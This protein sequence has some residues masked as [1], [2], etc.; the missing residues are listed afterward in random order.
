[1]TRA[2]PVPYVAATAAAIPAY[3]GSMPARLRTLAQHLLGSLW[4]IPSA[5]VFA[6][7]ALAVFM[8]ELSG[9]MGDAVLERFPRLFGASA[10]S[11]Q[12]MLSAI[13]GS[14][15]TVAGLSFSLV[16]LAV[17]QASSQYTPRILRTFM[18]DRANQ[19]VLGTFV[20]IFAYCLVVLR[21]IRTAD[22]GGFVPSLAVVL[23]IVLAIAGIG[24]LIYFVHHIASTL[25]A[26]S[27]MARVTRDTVVVVDRLFPQTLGDE[28]PVNG[29]VVAA[30][31]ALTDWHL[32]RAAATGYVQSVDEKGMLRLAAQTC[33]VIRMARGIGDFV[34]EGTE[35]AAFADWPP[36]AQPGRSPHRRDTGP[37]PAE[38]AKRLERLYVV[39]EYRTVAQDAAFGIRQLVD[40][41]L[42]ALSRGVND[43][44]TAVNCVD[45]IGAI[46]VRLANRQVE[47]PLRT[48]DGIVR[49]IARG[50]QF[51]GLLRLACDE[52]RN[53]AAGNP[54]MLDHLFETLG[55]VAGQTPSQDRRQLLAEQVRLIREVVSRTVET[56]HDRTRLESTADRV[57]AACER[58]P[59]SATRRGSARSR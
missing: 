37:D 52:I 18:E 53:S 57:A 24:V 11:S 2:A 3:S 21:T 51:D 23:A 38:I 26:S 30:I 16:L 19:V 39:D 20:G 46:L 9:G 42:R 7:L 15:I 28:G 6:A 33:Q 41:A 40:I 34:I 22:E 8:V 29:E 31:E 1:M 59:D 56:P 36:E 4:F 27:I 45:H 47:S 25:Q 50:A 14:M 54:A 5:I 12:A 10:A 58:G 13:A 35:I 32:A 48:R 43:T 17:T 49:V 44:T 55:T